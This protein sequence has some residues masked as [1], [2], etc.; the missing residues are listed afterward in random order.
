MRSTASII[1]HAAATYPARVSRPCRCHPARARVTV[2]LPAATSARRRST[3]DDPFHPLHGLLGLFSVGA[4]GAPPAR[5]PER[6]RRRSVHAGGRVR[7]AVPRASRSREENIESRSFQCQTRI[8]LV[9]HFQGRVSCP[10]GQGPRRS[11]NGADRRGTMLREA[12]RVVRRRARTAS[13]RRAFAQDCDPATT[14]SAAATRPARAAGSATGASSASATGQTPGADRL[15]ATPTPTSSGASSATSR[16]QLPDGGLDGKDNC[17][18]NKPKD[19]CV[20]GTDSRRVPRSAGSAAPTTARTA[21]RRTPS[22]ARAAATS[23]RASRRI[24]TSTSAPARR[25]SPAARSA[26]RRPRRHPDHRQVLH[27]V[28]APSYSDQRGGGEVQGARRAPGSA[29]ADRARL[30]DGRGLAAELTARG[31]SDA[32]RSAGR[33][34]GAQLRD[35]VSSREVS[36][37][38]RET[39]ASGASRSTSWRARPTSIVVVEVRTRGPASWQRALDSI[40]AKKRE[41]LRA[42]GERLWRERFATDATLERL[43]FDAMTVDVADGGG[44]ASDDRAAF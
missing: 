23:P 19:C 39:S 27:Q 25:A 4:V 10:L 9:N 26:R 21:T 44:A 3:F 35:L 11:C 17:D 28:R 36:S 42:A 6:R 20:P 31:A 22:T 8:C 16:T 12:R 14:T 33:R 41:R 24:R 30:D 18:G 29:F 7:P 5:V 2:P 32:R 37:P 43:R 1:V 38:R 34:R 15:P 13:R 40:D